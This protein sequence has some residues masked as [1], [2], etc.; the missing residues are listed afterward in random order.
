MSLYSLADVQ[1][2]CRTLVE[3]VGARKV[4]LP[5]HHLGGAAALPGHHHGR[6]HQQ[7]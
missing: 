3:G 6:C 2:V 5:R 7:E 4:V 1:K